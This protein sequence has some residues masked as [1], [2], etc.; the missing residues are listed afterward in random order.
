MIGHWHDTDV[1]HSVRLFA[2]VAIKYA[3]SWQLPRLH[4]E[5]TA[6]RVQWIL[7]AEGYGRMLYVQQ[8][9]G[10]D[11][12]GL[13]CSATGGGSVP[14]S[15]TRLYVCQTQEKFHSSIKHSTTPWNRTL[16]F[17]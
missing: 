10:A 7:G 1:C 5:A 14:K 6:K 15:E 16:C 4:R 12:Q 8:D 11:D 3:T 2:R 13:N 17:Y 9:D